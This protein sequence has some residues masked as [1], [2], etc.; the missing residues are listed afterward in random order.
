MQTLNDAKEKQFWWSGINLMWGVWCVL[1]CDQVGWCFMYAASEYR[2]DFSVVFQ[3][4]LPELSANSRSFVTSEWGLSSKHIIAV[5]P[6]GKQTHHHIIHLR[7]ERTA[8]QPSRHLN[9]QPS[10]SIHHQ[11]HSSDTS[12]FSNSNGTN[13]K[14]FFFFFFNLFTKDGKWKT[15]QSTYKVFAK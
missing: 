9:E 1:S 7:P 8:G 3:A 14:P 15:K 13:R 5:D 10:V 4:V 12:L 11:P 2:F 6:A